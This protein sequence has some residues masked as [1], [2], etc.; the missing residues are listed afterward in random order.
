ME[1]PNHLHAAD[2]SNSSK[3]TGLVIVIAIHVLAIMGLITALASGPDHEAA[4]GNQ[5]DGRSRQAPAQ[6]A[7][8]AA[9]GSGEAAAAGRHRPHIPGAAGSAAAGHGRAQAAAGAAQGRARRRRRPNSSRSRAP[10]RCRPI[11]LF[12]QRLGEQ[13]TTTM[14]SPSP[15]KATSPTARSPR[16][17]VRI[18]WTMRPANMSRSIGAGSRRPR[19][20]SRSPVSTQ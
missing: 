20:A 2:Q 18:V 10:T 15:P 11:R 17:A 16:P 4:S 5:G 3:L 9:A 14:K 7:A 13:G 1:R 8:A 6:G 12:R 19:K